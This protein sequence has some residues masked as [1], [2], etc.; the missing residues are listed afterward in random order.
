MA[1]AKFTLPADACIDRYIPRDG[2]IARIGFRA[3]GQNTLKEICCTAIAAYDIFN[4]PY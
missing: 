2:T 4:L 1:L 3:P